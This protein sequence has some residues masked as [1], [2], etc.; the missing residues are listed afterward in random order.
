M[1]T[2]HSLL[3]KNWG[4]KEYLSQITRVLYEV[5][6]GDD[7]LIGF[8]IAVQTVIVIVDCDKPHTKEGK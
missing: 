5:F 4:I 6:E 8:H 2:I 1:K 7:Q 3:S